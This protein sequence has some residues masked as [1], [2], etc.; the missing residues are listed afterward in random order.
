MFGS[1]PDVVVLQPCDAVATGK[2]M[3]HMIAQHGMAYM[4]TL[5]PKTPV[6]YDNSEQF[7][8]GGSKILR[9]SPADE[10]TVVATGITVFEALKA[11]DELTLPAQVQVEFVPEPDPSDCGSYY[12]AHHLYSARVLERLRELYG[13][14]GPDIVEFPDFLGEGLV[15]VQ[16]RRTYEPFLRDTQIHV[17]LH[18]SAEIRSVLDGYVDRKKAWKPGYLVPRFVMDAAKLAG[19]EGILYR[20]AR[21]LEG[22]NLV[23]F[24]RD[25][26]AECVGEAKRHEEQVC[27]K[28]THLPTAPRCPANSCANLAN[29]SPL[30]A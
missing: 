17:R 24:R 7:P 6:I 21:A 20:S 3:G 5:R 1:M 12:G 23:L 25:W 26:P 15:T 4:R 27:P 18:G 8:I 2:L 11:A 29:A 30:S 13:N 16:A 9:Q 10:L 14:R 19:F 22:Q 28:A